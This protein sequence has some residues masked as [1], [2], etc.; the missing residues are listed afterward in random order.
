MLEERLILFGLHQIEG[1]GY[2]TIQKLKNDLP[3]LQKL[4]KMDT[5]ELT[6][7]LKDEKK[8]KRIIQTLNE[9]YIQDK[10]QQYEQL[11]IQFLTILDP[12]YPYLLQQISDP[13]WVIYFK[14][15]H[16]ILEKPCIAIVG[17]RA[18]TVYGKRMTEQFAQGISSY[19]ICIVSGLARGIDSI[20]HIHSLDEMG[21]TIAVMG[22][23]LDTIYP[24]EHKELFHS[25]A[26]KGLLVSEYPLGTPS[27]PGLFPQRNR[28]IAG[29]CLGTIVV[30]AAQKS[31]SLITADLAM[32]YGRDVFAVPG[33]L[34]S[35][36]STGAI[37]LLKVGAKVLTTPLDILHEYEHR[38]SIEPKAAEASHH[39][40]NDLSTDEL[41]ILNL[42]QDEAL[43]FDRILEQ[44]QFTFG[45]LHSVLLSLLIKNK[46][47]QMIGSLYIRI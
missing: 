47:E 4:F 5:D 36:K 28:I 1:I 10:L 3:K 34:T 33:P 11:D 29:L 31:G 44:S 2:K 20:A 19:G 15:N 30:E 16:T 39:P 21:G 27:H 13:P 41:L 35:P 18:P 17:T 43:S 38:I 45:H 37:E 8:A 6:L 32:D 22:T 46:I 24:R 42:L 25:I 26:A 40:S 23:S 9:T 12:D 7:L 14:G